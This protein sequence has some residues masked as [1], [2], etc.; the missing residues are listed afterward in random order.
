MNDGKFGPE[1]LIAAHLFG[2]PEE[3]RDGFDDGL[4]RWPRL[5]LYET[6]QYQE[7]LAAR[8]P[9]EYGQGF[10]IGQRVAKFGARRALAADPTPTPRQEA[11]RWLMQSGRQSGKRQALPAPVPATG[12]T[13]PRKR[14]GSYRDPDL[15]DRWLAEAEHRAINDDSRRFKTSDSRRIIRRL[16]AEV[17]R[18]NRETGR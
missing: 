18:I 3:Y 10:R 4:R 2:K 11:R 9:G 13:A 12:T 16:V 6:R 8:T 17:R 7:M 5:P 15:S 14:T 1:T